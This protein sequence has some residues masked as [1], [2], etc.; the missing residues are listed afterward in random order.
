MKFKAACLLISTSMLSGC[1]E[2]ILD[3][4]NV[5]VSNGLIYEKA[6]NTPFSGQVTNIPDEFIRS[7]DDIRSLFTTH[8]TLMGPIDSQEALNMDNLVCGAGVEEGLLS[9][10]VECFLPRSETKRWEGSYEGGRPEG[11]FRI[12]SL[13]GEDIQAEYPFSN[14]LADGTSKFFGLNSNLIGEFNN[15]AG[16]GHGK[17]KQWDPQTGN[18]TYSADMVNGKLDGVVRSWS[19]DGVLLVEAPMKNGLS[20]GVVTEWDPET[21]QKI[22]ETTMA[23]GVRN[24]P[25]AKWDTEGNRIRSG[26]YVENSWYPD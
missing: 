26:T 14:G 8:Y 21:G 7:T 3:W 24:G 11:E 19:P 2:D 12:Y 4:R 17:Q 1:G 6:S 15:N 10:S 16:K 9:G 23:E 20:H 13:N 18:L 25:A 5:E 22:A